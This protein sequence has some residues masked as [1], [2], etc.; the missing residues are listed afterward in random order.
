[1]LARCLPRH[2]WNLEAHLELGHLDTWNLEMELFFAFRGVRGWEGGCG[3]VARCWPGPAGGPE[4]RRPETELMFVSHV[5]FPCFAS[6]LQGGRG[7]LHL[8]KFIYFYP[9]LLLP[10]RVVEA[11]W[12]LPAANPDDY[13]NYDLKEQGWRSYQ[14]LVRSS[15][16]RNRGVGG[17]RK[18][19]AWVGWGGVGGGYQK[20]VRSW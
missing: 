12:R 17:A 2:T 10:C 11:P 3:W 9:C 20:L 16:L 6:A 1:M 13:F 4:T 7:P 14:K 15:S 5:C 18:R 19:G 8:I